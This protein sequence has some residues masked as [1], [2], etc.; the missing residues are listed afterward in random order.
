M[1]GLWS[2]NFKCWVTPT[3]YPSQDTEIIASMSSANAYLHTQNQHM[4]WDL[5][6]A[7]LNNESK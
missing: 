1:W 6:H 2:K 5:Y 7:S 3:L 4:F